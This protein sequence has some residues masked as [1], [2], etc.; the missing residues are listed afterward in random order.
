MSRHLPQFNTKKY[1]ENISLSK[2]LMMMCVCVAVG[3]GSGGKEPSENVKFNVRLYCYIFSPSFVN[4][5]RRLLALL[6][7]RVKCDTVKACT[8]TALN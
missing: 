3:V 1:N 5:T 4:P 8:H 2:I 6:F 7:I